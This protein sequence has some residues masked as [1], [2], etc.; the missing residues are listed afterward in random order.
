MYLPKQKQKHNPL[1]ITLKLILGD[2]NL[3]LS[4]RNYTN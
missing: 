4:L 1:N 3:H 2:K